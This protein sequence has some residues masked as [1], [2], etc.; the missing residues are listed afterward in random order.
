MRV[1]L[2]FPVFTITSPY[3]RPK[4][5]P[6]KKDD[7]L[8]RYNTGQTAAEEN[9]VVESWYVQMGEDHHP[10]S[11]AID[12][13]QKKAK[14]WAG[15]QAKRKPAVKQSRLWPKLVAAAAILC[16]IAGTTYFFYHNQTTP[17]HATLAQ[18]IAPGKIGATLT[19]ADG[20]KIRLSEAAKGEL[21]KEAGLTISK[22]ADGQII[23]SATRS[24]EENK[25]NTLST[26]RGE[27]YMIV[28]SDQTKVWL[29]AASSL[30][31]S[32]TLNE[33]GQRKVILTGEAYFEVAKDKAHPFI[34][35][36]GKQLVQVLGTHFNINSYSDEPGIKTTLLEGSV[37]VTDGTQSKTLRPGQQADLNTKINI[38]EV[39]AETAL[40]W[41]NGYFDFRAAE[42]ADVMK[43]I[44]RWY[45]GIEAVEIKVTIDDQFTATIPRNVT[46]STMLRILEETSKVKFDMQGKKIIVTK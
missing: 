12:Y 6:A 23:Y 18:D 15:I 29:N 28:L 2:E 19:L 39:D 17:D 32:A 44:K 34:V 14:I 43:E 8:R 42:F 36:S 38:S 31:Y 11:K 33:N 24:N 10:I 37:K 5:E 30:T 13:E 26:A 4:M 40:A 45:E 46:L 35:E 7:L 3:K 41:K 25:I 9:A 27:T 22:T 21:A 1:V 16:A 20:K